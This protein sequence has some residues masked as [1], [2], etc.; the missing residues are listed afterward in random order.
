MKVSNQ[1]KCDSRL[2]QGSSIFSGQGSHLRP[3]A[4]PHP[5][6]PSPAL[7]SG[8]PQRGAP[9][10]FRHFQEHV[11]AHEGRCWGEGMRWR[12]KGTPS[13][14]ARP[15]SPLASTPEEG[16]MCADERHALLMYP[17][18]AIVEIVSLAHGVCCD[19]LGFCAMTVSTQQS[20]EW[21]LRGGGIQ[22]FG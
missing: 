21:W 8:F 20:V 17:P 5:P 16:N 6:L 4:P 3:N 7:L 18:L 1:W 14:P 22:V 12:G 11:E 9:D 13:T 10:V 15:L 19:C 2:H